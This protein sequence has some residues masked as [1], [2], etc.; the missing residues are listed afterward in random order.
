MHLVETCS[1][2][3]YEV[4]TGRC[5]NRGLVLSSQTTEEIDPFAVTRMFERDFSEEFIP[6]LG[7]S[8]KTDDSSPSPGKEL[9]N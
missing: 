6:G 8:K 2:Y 4:D 3:A 9:P 1:L 5:S 7:L